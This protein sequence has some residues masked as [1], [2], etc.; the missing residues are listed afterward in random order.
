MSLGVAS[1]VKEKQVCK[2]GPPR[3]CLRD[4]KIDRVPGGRLGYGRHFGCHLRGLDF[5]YAS[6]AFSVS[7]ITANP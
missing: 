5:F 3:E 7:Y 2:V 1:P 4:H 6:K